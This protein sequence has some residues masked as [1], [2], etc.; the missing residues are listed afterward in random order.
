MGYKSGILVLCAILLVGTGYAQAQGLDNVFRDGS[1]N[2]E[3]RIYDF[4][5]TFSSPN[6]LNKNGFASA[7]LLNAQTATFGG[8]FTVAASLLSGSALGTQ[9]TNP[10]TRQ[11]NMLV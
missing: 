4:N 3:V 11:P 10:A 1:I 8:G 9:A 5:S 6:T 2:D 7:V